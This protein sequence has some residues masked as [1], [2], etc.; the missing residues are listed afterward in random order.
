HGGLAQ[1]IG[2]ALLE[3]VAY[4]SGG[5]LLTGSFTD[6]AMPRADDLP[7]FMVGLNE[8]P[9]KTNPL[10]VKGTGEAGWVGGPPV[11]IH[12]VLDALDSLGVTALD[13]PATPQQVWGAIVEAAKHSQS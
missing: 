7:S 11:V 2:Q 13:M 1:G 12:P 3:H 9:A 5:Q 8:V 4:D 6:Y 10:G